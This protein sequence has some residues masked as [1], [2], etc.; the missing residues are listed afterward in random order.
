MTAMMPAARILAV[1]LA[2]TLLGLAG[3]FYD[4]ATGLSA[5]AGGALCLG[6][7]ALAAAGL[8]T[9]RRARDPRAEGRRMLRARVVRWAAG[10]LG[11]GLLLALWPEVRPLPLFGA[12]ALA[13]AAPLLWH[14]FDGR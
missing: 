10:L 1:Q 6:P 7:N 12:Y 4:R 9:R 14:A 2:I 3:I 8:F 11:L 5:A 13:L